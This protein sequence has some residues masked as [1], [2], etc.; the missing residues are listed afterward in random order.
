MKIVDLVPGSTHELIIVLPIKLPDL[1]VGWSESAFL[2]DELRIGKHD[3]IGRL[4]QLHHVHRILGQFLPLLLEVLFPFLLA[5][6][7]LHLFISLLLLLF[8]VLLN[9]DLAMLRQFLLQQLIS[10]HPLNIVLL[11]LELLFFYGILL[12]LHFLDLL[13]QLC[14]SELLNFLVDRLL[15]L[16]VLLYR[17]ASLGCPLEDVTASVQTLFAHYY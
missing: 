5:I 11:L 1:V 3:Q 14:L 4:V 2:V 12:C 6:Y 10:F 17:N 7:V 9:F 13:F 8:L 15:L 16:L